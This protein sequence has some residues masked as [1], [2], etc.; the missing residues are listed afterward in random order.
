MKLNVE[1]TLQMQIQDAILDLIR[2]Q[3]I[4]PGNQLPTE[5]EL[6]KILGVGRS[7]LRE[8]LANL[9]HQ[10]ILYKVQ[11]KGTFVR[12]IPVVVENGLDILRGVT[13][14]ILAVG[15][16]PST[17]RMT[18]KKIQAGNS[19]AKK[20][21]L[22]SSDECYWVERVRRADD[23]VAVYCIDI[24]P[25]SMVP[26]NFNEEEFKGSIFSIL[27]KSGHIV[28]YTE[29]SIHPTILTKR[30]LPEMKTEIGMF[31]LLEEIYYDTT[32]VPVSYGNDYYSAEIFDFK[33]ARK[34]PL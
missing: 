26:E 6:I 32:G 30:D 14:N 8:A 12:E 34:R 19:L 9:V 25:V 18:V 7:T 13:E 4:K 2:T 20:L 15:A 27:E 17:S 22:N 3:K 10:G 21:K 23:V 11:G 24:L 5:T 33:I 28:S 29:T 16:T 1:K 31:L